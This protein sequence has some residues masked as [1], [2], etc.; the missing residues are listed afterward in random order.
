MKLGPGVA[1]AGAVLLLI[2]S[3]A[4]GSSPELVID[5]P[6]ELAAVA[7]EIRT[8]GRGD[9]SAEL[10]I[11]GVMGFTAPIRVVVA[12]ERSALAERT[13][14]W[15]SGYADGS[16]RVVVLFPSRVARYPDDSLVNLVHHEVTHVLVAE[17]ARGRPVPRWFNE[18]IA[19][20]AAREWGLEDRA[21]YTAAV[22]LGGPESVADLD[23]GF[24]AGGRQASRAYA[25][26][27]AFVRWLQSKYGGA[28][29]ARILALIADDMGFREAFVRATGD[30]V[31]RAEYRFFVREALWHTWLPF[32]TS[33]GLLWTM[34]TAL[35]LIA[36]Q[37]RRAR[38]A[39]MRRQWEEEDRQ[40]ERQLDSGPLDVDDG[41]DGGVVN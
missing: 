14:A 36:I 25:L 35:A 32:L 19:T 34:I 28:V 27:S 31:E 30:T 37:R 11:T 4:A 10:L 1:T 39:A 21:R 40:L 12:P 38:S 26:S 18:G 3:A 23:R 13:P 15:V 8:I 17:A 29:T 6:P 5:A 7:D 41:D 9:F 2:A 22:V 20:V 16:A 33:S 24:A